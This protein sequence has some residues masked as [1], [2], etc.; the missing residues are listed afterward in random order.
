MD[1]NEGLAAAIRAIMKQRHISLTEFAEELDISRGAL[2]LYA[3]GEGNPSIST[4]NHIARRLGVSPAVLA[5]GLKELDHQEIA[6]LLLDTIQGVAELPEEKRRQMAEH[7]LE[8][9]KLWN[10]S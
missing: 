8:M 9:I 2:H 3:K 7:F 4:L 6:L 10:E 1:L 5:N